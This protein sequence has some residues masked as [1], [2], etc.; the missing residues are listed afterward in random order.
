MISEISP[1]DELDPPETDTVMMNGKGAV[2]MNSVT[3][4]K[5]ASGQM[6]VKID[7]LID[8]DRS[9]EIVKITKIESEDE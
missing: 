9:E 7:R 3:L 5:I 6:P 8:V 4:A 2:V 1:W